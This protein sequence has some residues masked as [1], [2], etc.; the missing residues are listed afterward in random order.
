MSEEA[1]KINLHLSVC[2]SYSLSNLNPI[3]KNLFFF[4]NMSE[5]GFS[6]YE[7]IA[8]ST[9]AKISSKQSQKPFLIKIFSYI[10]PELRN[11]IFYL[12][13]MHFYSIFCSDLAA[14][15]E[16]NSGDV[17]DSD[18]TR[19]LFRF[20]TTTTT[21]TTPMPMVQSIDLLLTLNSMATGGG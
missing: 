8:N 18:K 20:T 7:I 3:S 13:F 14:A 2:S 10:L 17:I 12:I 19:F 4:G 15:I 11:Q 9:F 5:K 6:F 21:T 16:S 1:G